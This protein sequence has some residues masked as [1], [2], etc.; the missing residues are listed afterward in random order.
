MWNDE[1]SMRRWIGKEVIVPFSSDI[2]T[3]TL[4]TLTYSVGME[5]PMALTKVIYY[6]KLN[7]APFGNDLLPAKI[8]DIDFRR[9]FERVYIK[10]KNGWDCKIKPSLI[11][12]PLNY[13]DFSI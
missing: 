11:V 5:I 7:S 2:P 3:T 6:T 12:V 4:D 8:V 1:R 13:S 9:G 10:W